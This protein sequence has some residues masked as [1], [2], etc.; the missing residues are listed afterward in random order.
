[1]AD[2]MDENIRKRHIERQRKRMRQMK[3]RR[4]MTMSL[5]VILVLLIIILFTPIF[6]IR[7]VEVSGNV[8]V[9]ADEIETKL[10]SCIGKN[11]FRYR[12]GT[13]VKNI[14]SIPYVDSARIKKSV[15]STKLTVEI[16]ECI[17]AAYI[18]V[19]EKYI[20]IDSKLKVLEVTEEEESDIPKITD[21]S[22]P[23]V[24]L[25][26][27]LGIQGEETLEAVK[28]CLPLL[29]EEG[30]LAG[31]EYISFK[32]VEDITFNY[33]NR[34]DVVCG[35]T[36]DFQKKLRLFNQA[37]NTQTLAENSRGTIDLSVSNHAVYSP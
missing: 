6:K 28:T 21:I 32:D 14:K 5:L 23:S 31:V 10:N 20:I 9:T 27:T 22:A 17:P 25:G 36:T 16:T 3:R 1:M 4:I 30:L 29:E 19:G 35:D 12:T 34:L 26:E 8:R 15:F 2:A 24:T 18:D 33:Q 37:I 13:P 11:I 7:K